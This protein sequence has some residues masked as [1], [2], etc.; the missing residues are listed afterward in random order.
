[1]RVDLEDD[2][3]S[4]AVVRKHMAYK[5]KQWVE[6]KRLATMGKAESKDEK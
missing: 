4:R 5:S 1:M 6:T 3:Y 2:D